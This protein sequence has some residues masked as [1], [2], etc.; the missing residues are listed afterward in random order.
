MKRIFITGKPIQPA[1]TPTPEAW[2]ANH[3]ASREPI[4]RLTVDIPLALHHRV[5]SDCAL[6]GLKMSDVI[7]DLLEA[8][9]R[10]EPLP[11]PLAGRLE[12]P[13]QQSGNAIL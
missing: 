8:H 13:N 2:V 12:S 11:T 4:K 7:R 5:K 10:T 3:P 6:R 9:F 1:I